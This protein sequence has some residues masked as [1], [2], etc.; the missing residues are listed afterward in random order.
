LQ[1]RKVAFKDEQL[2]AQECSMGDLENG[3][4]LLLRTF[5]QGSV[6]LLNILSAKIILKAFCSGVL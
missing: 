6:S 1:K 4:E 3:A 5:I 2:Q